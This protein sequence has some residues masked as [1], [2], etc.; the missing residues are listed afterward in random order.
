MPIKGDI[1]V[2]HDVWFGYKSLIQSGVS[3]GSGSIVAAGANVVKDVPPYSVVA[4]NPGKVVKRRFDEKT[5]EA[6]L[7]ISWWDW[8][9]NKITKNLSAIVNADLNKLK[10]LS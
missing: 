4:G 7:E 9:I 1:L 10:N 3:I 6:L 2:G 8:D 5:I